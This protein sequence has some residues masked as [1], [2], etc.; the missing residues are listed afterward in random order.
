MSINQS[1][2]YLSIYLQVWILQGIPEYNAFERDIAVLN[3]FFGDSTVLGTFG[4]GQVKNV[5]YPAPD[6]KISLND[7]ENSP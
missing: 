2:A 5:F 6:P 1:K 4:R 3:V 7:L